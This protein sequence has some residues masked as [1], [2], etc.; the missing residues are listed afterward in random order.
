MIKNTF[1]YSISALILL[2]G[3]LWIGV[4]CNKEASIGGSDKEGNLSLR[5]SGIEL[6]DGGG[7]FADDARITSLRIMVFSPAGLDVQKHFKAAELS[8]T[9]TIKAHVGSDRTIYVIANEPAAITP[10]LDDVLFYS[11]LNAIQ[12]IETAQTQEIP[13]LMTGKQTGVTIAEDN[14]SSI[15]VTLQRVVA[16]ISLEI[17]KE[18]NSNTDEVTITSLA[19]QRNAKTG[20]LFAAS[21]LGAYD[22]ALGLWNWEKNYNGT[23]LSL[24]GEFQSVMDNGCIYVYEN[25]GII[26]ADTTDRASRLE[27]KALFNGIPT[28]YRAYINDET[29]SA[30]HHYSIL[31]NHHYKVSATISK[32]GETNVLLLST[33][34]LPWNVEDVNFDFVKPYLV[35]IDPE[36]ALTEEQEVSQSSPLVLRVKIKAA[37]HSR[38]KATLSNGLDFGFKE[39]GDFVS[40]GDADGE[41]EYS[42][43]ILPLK[44]PGGGV[45][46]TTLSFAVGGNKVLN[47]A[48]TNPASISIIQR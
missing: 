29:T 10:Q 35:S 28:T 22:P 7:L 24:T 32:L 13:L 40:E 4:A 20:T 37:T 39:E 12:P 43:K 18:T 33:K 17:K 48:H 45:R 44:A 38:W 2:L 30:D 8:E 15:S 31:R 46:R 25:P 34:V 41:T 14:S 6:R 11:D 21:P 5:I 19:I 3:F 26:V 23:H 47:G 1:T 27:V 42:L 9:M 36:S 16:K